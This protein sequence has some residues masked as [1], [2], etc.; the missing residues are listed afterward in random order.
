MLSGRFYSDTY[1]SQFKCIVQ[2]LCD[3]HN[4][5]LIIFRHTLITVKL[6]SEVLIARQY[7]RD[8]LNTVY[9]AHIYNSNKYYNRNFNYMGEQQSCISIVRMCRLT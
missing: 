3:T 9:P 4:A 1:I 5:T 8:S 6:L 7:N 2:I